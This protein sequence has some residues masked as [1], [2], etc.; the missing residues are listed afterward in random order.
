MRLDV[1][2]ALLFRARVGG[3]RRCVVRLDR[4]V[5]EAALIEVVRTPVFRSRVLL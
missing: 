1:I 3:F 4:I 5:V 2:G